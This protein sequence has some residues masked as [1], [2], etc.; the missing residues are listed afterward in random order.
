MNEQQQLIAMLERASV[1]YDT[2]LILRQFWI[3]PNGVHS[4]SNV[5]RITTYADDGKYRATLFHFDDVGVLRDVVDE[6]GVL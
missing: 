4:D 6:E 3:L 1:S 5:V 2:N